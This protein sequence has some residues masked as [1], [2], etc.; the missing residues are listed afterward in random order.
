MKKK[1]V[2]KKT[3]KGFKPAKQPAAKSAKGRPGNDVSQAIGRLAGIGI[4]V[5][6]VAVIV[7]MIASAF[8][9]D[10]AFLAAPRAWISR[11][12]TPVQSTFSMATD[13]VVG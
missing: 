1:Q 5:A 6:L 3:N 11:L 4:V 7:M 10:I 9:G 12:I 13:G 8:F 2:Q